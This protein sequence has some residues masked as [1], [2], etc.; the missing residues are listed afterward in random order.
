M[1]RSEGHFGP[2][3]DQKTHSGNQNQV[4]G[5]TASFLARRNRRFL[6]KCARWSVNG[7]HASSRSSPGRQSATRARIVNPCLASLH[8]AMGSFGTATLRRAK[9]TSC[10]AGTPAQAGIRQRGRL[11]ER[12]HVFPIQPAPSPPDVGRYTVPARFSCQSVT[13]GTVSAGSVRVVTFP[14]I[15][16]G[17]C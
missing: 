1:A 11:L 9:R 4:H 5:P 2:K 14:D 10:I 12:A 17:Y 16:V 15:V 6:L 7:S 13:V 3:I 8:D